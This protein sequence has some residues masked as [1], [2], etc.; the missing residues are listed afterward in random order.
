MAVLHSILMGKFVFTCLNIRKMSKY[1]GAPP[2]SH[3]A[4]HLTDGAVSVSVSLRKTDKT[5]Y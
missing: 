4:K 1:S 2:A 3:F 5:L